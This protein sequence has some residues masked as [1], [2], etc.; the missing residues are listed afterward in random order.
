MVVIS[1]EAKKT[2]SLYSKAVA[3]A[4]GDRDADFINPA[5]ANLKG[6]QP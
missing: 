6:D 4:T 5:A 1:P 3:V 2:R